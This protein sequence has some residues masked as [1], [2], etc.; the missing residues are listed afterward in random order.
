EA[1]TALHST[2]T[3][4][5][6]EWLYILLKKILIMSLFILDSVDNSHIL[7]D[8]AREQ[9]KT[10][11]LVYL[12]GD[13][14]ANVVSPREASGIFSYTPEFEFASGDEDLLIRSILTEFKVKATYTKDTENQVTILVELPVVLA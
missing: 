11:I 9:E 12:Q 13:G 8:V 1:Q 10:K 6:E 4:I 14:L 7:V 3:T 5:P 2:P